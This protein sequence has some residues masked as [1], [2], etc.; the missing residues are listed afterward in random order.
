MNLT[1]SDDLVVHFSF[2]NNKDKQR[3]FAERLQLKFLSL[4]EEEMEQRNISKKHLADKLRVSKSYVSQIFA[5]DALLNVKTLG[6]IE[7]MLG[8]QFD[9]SINTKFDD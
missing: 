4:V 8:I 2:K 9:V 1:S 3:F 7:D 5:A 6:K